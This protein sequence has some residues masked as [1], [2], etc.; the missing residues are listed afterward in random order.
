MLGVDIVAEP[1]VKFV[2]K[3][4]AI[5]RDNIDTDQIIP[6]IEMRSQL[7]HNY[8][9]SLFAGWRYSDIEKRSENPDFVLNQSGMDQVRILVSGHNFGCGSSREH[10]VWALRDYGIRVVMARSFGI[11]FYENCINNNV[12]PIKIPN[13]RLLNDQELADVQKFEVDLQNQIVTPLS[14]IEQKWNF[15][16]KAYH[17]KLLIE[18]VDPI[19]MTLKNI[20]QI[21]AFYDSDTR[22]RPWLYAGTRIRSN[23]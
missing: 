22:D 23:P 19:A 9:K 14:K 12:L 13:D 20:E 15:E 17:K 8:A 2:G 10:A 4:V 16:I 7:G 5:V 18:G 3:A 21:R 6:S 11:I 1:F